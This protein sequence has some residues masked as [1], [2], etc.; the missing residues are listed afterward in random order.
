MHIQMIHAEQYCLLIKWRK[1]YEYDVF[2]FV[3]PVIVVNWGPSTK[4]I[5]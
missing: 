5:I 2:F 4:G 3:K 1:I